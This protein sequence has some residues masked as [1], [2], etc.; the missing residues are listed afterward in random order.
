[1]VLIHAIDSCLAAALL[2]VCLLILISGLDDL[3]LIVVCLADSFRRRALYA[4]REENLRAVPEKR[5][6]IFVP[7]WHEA[8][9]IG[10]MI[11]HNISAIRYKRYD[12][13]VGAYPNDDPTMDAVRELETRFPNVH[14]AVCP[15][16]G[17]TS[18]A[19][20]LNWIYQRM[21]VYE[22]NRR[23][24][25]DAVVVHDAEDLIHADSLRTTNFYL[26]SYHMVQ[27][28][29]LALPTPLKNLTQGIYCDDFAESQIKD[30]RVRGLMHSFIPS[31]GVGAAYSRRALQR[32]A[33]SAGNRIFEPT[34]LTEDYENGLRLHHLGC[35]QIFVPLRFAAADIVATREYFPST[36]ASAIR[37]RTRW[38]TGIALQTWERHGWSGALAQRYWFWRDRKGLY[39]S[40][41][42][43]AAN[44]MFAAGCLNWALAR[45]GGR[46]WA[47]L[48][49]RL[50]LGLL[51]A[52][53]TLQVIHLGARMFCVSRV[54]GWPY[55]L[56][57]PLRV[58][59]GNY[60]NASASIRA[61]VR[62]GLA[63]WRREPLVWVK[64][65]HAY[66]SRG[67][68]FVHKRRLGEVLVGS[69]YIQP[70]T[71]AAA[72]ASQP[73]GV[74]LGEHLMRIGAISE[75]ELYEALSLQ[76]SVPAG[77]V[78]PLEIN[79]NVARCLPR[80]VIHAW[81][82][83][84]F[85]MVEGNLF[86]ASPEIP[87]DELSRQLRDFTRLSLQFRLVTPENF[88]E[89]TRCLL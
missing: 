23:I 58:V 5:L 60:I 72:L 17:P 29:V 61:L 36:A 48:E 81:K 89:L 53:C 47:L 42:G 13:F 82:V 70:G 79:T 73:A 9:V 18:K 20:C 77:R 56:G 31:N 65:E 80:R 67:A 84:P 35:R 7:C 15:H 50:P 24:R 2:P 45:L 68:L 52:I 6:A 57:V 4:P 76:Q 64:T 59:W 86:L 16:D 14:L 12:F 71:L 87:T 88:E 37:Q 54:Y 3:I 11:E 85:R 1:M 74:R 83:L 39:S 38:V 62:Y 78:S 30:M 32:L 40:P 25:F 27:I 46:H 43:F 22:E 55:S 19:D 41:L 49:H 63:R 10:Q 8:A 69:N 21:L 28:P 33:A 44:L 51:I 75:D 34:C 26:D 66:P